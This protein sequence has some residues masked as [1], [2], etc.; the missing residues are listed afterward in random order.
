MGALVVAVVPNKL[1]PAGFA[2]NS[3]PGCV[4]VAVPNSPPPDVVDVPNVLVGAEK[5]GTLPPI[6]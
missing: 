4:V 1:L 6:R 2:P 3:D 5:Y